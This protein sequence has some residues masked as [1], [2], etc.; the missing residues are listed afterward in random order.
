MNFQ[1][2]MFETTVDLRARAAALASAAAA[3]ARA[4]ARVAAKRIDAIKGSLAT[5]TVA[6]RKLNKVARRHA[7]RF[8][9]ENASL[10]ADAGKD[11][12]ALARTTYAT[13]AKRTPAKRSAHTSPAARKRSASKA[14]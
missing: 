9:K 12:S 5:L 3:N 11:V 14:A 4:G 1:E 7:V 13:L 6:G 2:K 10:A 8:M